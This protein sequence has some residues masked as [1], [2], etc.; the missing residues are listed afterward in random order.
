MESEAGA[1][2]PALPSPGLKQVTLEPEFP[3]KMGC[4]YLASQGVK[5]DEEKAPKVLSM[6]AGA[7]C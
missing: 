5:N 1:L 3:Y 2:L 6:E 7:Q 4:Y